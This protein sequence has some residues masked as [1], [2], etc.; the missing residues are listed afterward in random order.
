MS[1][2]F[3]G[4][5]SESKEYYSK[6]KR[7]LVGQL[8]L[9]ARG[10]LR[11]MMVGGRKY[12]YL[13]DKSHEKPFDRYVGPADSWTANLISESL[14]RRKLAISEIRKAK[15]AL[16]KLGVTSMSIKNEDFFPELR[17]IL[18]LLN[19]HGLWEQ[20]LEIIGSWCFKIYQSYYGVEFYPERTLDVDFAIPLPYQG[21]PVDL[22]NLFKSLGFQEEFNYTDESVSYTAGEMKIEILTHRK[23]SGKEQTPYVRDL[24]IAPQALPYLSML[25]D[26]PVAVQARDL[27][28]AMVP[29]MPAFFLHKLIVAD[30]RRKEDKKAKDYRQV[31]AVAKALLRDA[32]L[33]AETG[34]IAAGLHK[35]WRQRIAKSSRAIADYV[36]ASQG[37][38]QA[39]LQRIGLLA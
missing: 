31:E 1:L 9:N 25:L 38:A 20:G 10:S 18:N 28:R 35:K 21:N 3:E 2:A 29:A 12:A 36:P 23:G 30:A 17:K 13:R 19:E 16:K 22:G 4:V 24:G 14:Q 5:L 6:L 26:H 27:G 37:A 39:V 7:R 32:G 34:R 33:L 11:R 8:L 15:S